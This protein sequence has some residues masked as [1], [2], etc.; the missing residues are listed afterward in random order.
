LS[1]GTESANRVELEGTLAELGTLRHTPAGIAVI[2]FRIA[3]QSER[4]EAGGRRKVHAEVA[5]LAFDST[6]RLIAGQALG[7]RIR[8]DGFLCARNRRSRVAVLHVTDIEF[9]QG[10]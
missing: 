10:E 4:P 9:M 1:A 5:A 7:A 8:A 2:E 6:A 3:H